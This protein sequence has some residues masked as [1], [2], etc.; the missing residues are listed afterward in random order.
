MKRKNDQAG[1]NF[2]L[3][4]A[5]GVILLLFSLYFIRE[6]VLLPCREAIASRSWLPTQAEVVSASLTARGT[7]LRIDYRYTVGGR[8]YGSRRYD[9]FGRTHGTAE[10]LL[11]LLRRFP[12]GKRITC[13]AD[14]RRPFEAVIE[15]SVPGRYYVRLAA[16]LAG[17]AAGLLLIVCAFRSRFRRRPPVQ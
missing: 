11:P 14:P 17:A 2:K 6:T 4:T 3:M 7:E 5:S 16:G 8:P 10:T 13:H 9:F 12:A 15:R 1:N